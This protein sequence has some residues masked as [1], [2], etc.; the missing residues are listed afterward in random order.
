MY[1][2]VKVDEM[3]AQEYRVWWDLHIRMAKCENLSAAELND[4]NSGLRELDADDALSMRQEGGLDSLRDTRERVLA[5]HAEHQRLASQYEIMR[6]EMT[7]LES[8][9]DD[10]AK[11]ALGVGR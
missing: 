8:L 6:K 1:K 11:L 7:R 9:L 4:Y 10:Q 3:D 2:F 5:A